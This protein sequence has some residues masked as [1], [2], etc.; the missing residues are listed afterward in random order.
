M[1]SIVNVVCEEYKI[2]P[3]SLSQQK[4]VRWTVLEAKSVCI[5]FYFRFMKVIL[6]EIAWL[7]F[8][9][10]TKHDRVIY[11]V[12]QVNKELSVNKDFTERIQ[13]LTL[14]LKEEGYRD[15]D[16]KKKKTVVTFE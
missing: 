9:D 7:F 8:A 3:E 1:K 12:K 4:E 2:S 14:I 15:F 6:K 5:Y 13:R 10:P 11:T 16:R